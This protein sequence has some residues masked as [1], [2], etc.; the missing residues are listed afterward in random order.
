MAFP[1]RG[2]FQQNARSEDSTRHAWPRARWWPGSKPYFWP[3]RAGKTGRL[4]PER[5]FTSPT[6]VALMAPLALTSCR[7]IL[8]RYR[9]T[10]LRLGLADIGGVD[11]AVPVRV[12]QQDAERERR[13]RQNLAELSVTLLKL[14]VTVC[15]SAIPARFTVIVFSENVGLPHH[16]AHATGDAGVAAHDRMGE[17]EDDGEIVAR[18]ATPAFHSRCAGEGER[19]CRTCRPRRASSRET[20]P[21]SSRRTDPRPRIARPHCRR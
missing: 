6:S 2:V 4:V 10:G 7:R 9:S 3:T 19:R 11:R 18:A 5:A 13:I 1:V 17:T 16:A 15:A 21:S 14:R 12:A 20:A 8:R